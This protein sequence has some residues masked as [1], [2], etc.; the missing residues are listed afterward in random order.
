MHCMS[1]VVIVAPALVIVAVVVIVLVVAAADSDMCCAV[2]YDK[3]IDPSTMSE[4]LM[5]REESTQRCQRPPKKTKVD[6]KM[7]SRR[8]H[9]VCL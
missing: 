2:H 8:I 3:V 5:K 7:V 6:K 4:D 1:L 9:L